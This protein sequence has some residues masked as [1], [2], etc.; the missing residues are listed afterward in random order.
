MDLVHSI[1]TMAAAAKERQ[2]ACA[3]LVAAFLDLVAR[4]AADYRSGADAITRLEVR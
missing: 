2:I 1:A 3:D 4:Q